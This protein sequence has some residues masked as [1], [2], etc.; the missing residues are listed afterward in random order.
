MGAAGRTMG[1]AS[2]VGGAKVL[3]QDGPACWRAQGG[4]E[5]TQT[6]VPRWSSCRERGRCGDQ[7]AR[8]FPEGRVAWAVAPGFAHTSDPAPGTSLS[9][10]DG[11]T[12][13]GPLPRPL[14][15]H[16]LEG[17]ASSQHAQDL[18]ATLPC[19]PGP[20]LHTKRLKPREGK[21]APGATQHHQGQ[22]S[23]SPSACSHPLSCWLQLLVVSRPPWLQP[24]TQLPPQ[25]ACALARGGW[26][27][28]PHLT[29]RVPRPSPSPT[30]PTGG[31]EAGGGGKI[32][33]TRTRSS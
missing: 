11:S 8:G 31:G 5:R 9:A 13:N 23:P 30:A 28:R 7:P 3:G 22:S 14:S 33:H 18:V 17:L 24:G 4:L 19:W 6:R 10:S 1:W 15:Y 25:Q 21:I 32:I 12:Q 29:P 26:A 20:G 2:A 27:G 16:H